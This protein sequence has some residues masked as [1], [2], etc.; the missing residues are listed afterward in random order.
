MEYDSLVYQFRLEEEKLVEIYRPSSQS[1]IIEAKVIQRTRNIWDRRRDLL[2]HEFRVT[3]RNFIPFHY[4]WF[5]VPN[6]SH[7]SF[8]NRKMGGIRVEILHMLARSLN[9]TVKFVNAW[10]FGGYWGIWKNGRWN[11]MLGEWATESS[12]AHFF[13][14]CHLRMQS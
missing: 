6:G 9:F 3:Y 12:R 13:A 14:L 4:D 8:G 11:G 7:K 10:E 5:M 1:D 2:G